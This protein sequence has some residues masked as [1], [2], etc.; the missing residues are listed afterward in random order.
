MLDQNFLRNNVEAVASRLATRGYEIPMDTF[1][2]LDAERR[3]LIAET[4]KLKHERNASSETI[5][6]LMREKQD[7]EPL[8]NRVRDL[9][10]LIK[11]MDEKLRQ[12]EL[13]LRL[14]VSEIP[15]LPHESVPVGR[16]ESANRVERVVGEPPSFDF[17]PRSHWEIG[18]SLGILDFERAARLAGARFAVLRGAGALLER[19]LIGL[20]LDIHTRERGY[21]EM[22][23]PFL[24]N[25]ET[26]FGTGQLPKFE[27]DLF[28]VRDTDYY[29]IPTAEVPLTGLHA[30]EILQPETLPISYCAYTPCFRSE[31]GSYGKDVRGHLRQHQ[32]NKVELVKLTEPDRS[33]AALEQ[34]TSDAEEILKRL[35]LAYRVVSLCTGDLGFSST[36]TYDLEVWLPGQGCY[37]EISSCSNCEDFQARRANI[38]FRQEPKGRPEFV[39]TLNGSGLAVGRTLIAILENYQRADGSVEVP[40]ALRPYAGGLEAVT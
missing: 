27:Q 26:L 3:H 38:R 21:T 22:L 8:K 34:L 20:M 10:N 16:D 23:P 40:P 35:G 15:N 1:G 30:G 4:E 31:A 17:T 25:S 32:F 7:A 13:S 9:G 39:H 36:K 18:E 2:Q 19:A 12:T 37:R 28:K 5:G 29:L 14:L 33:Y 24:A 6:R 11:E